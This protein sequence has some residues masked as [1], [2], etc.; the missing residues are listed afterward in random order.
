MKAYEMGPAWRQWWMNVNACRALVPNG[1][2]CQMLGWQHHEHI[3]AGWR[4]AR[5]M[6]S[7][8]REGQEGKEPES[9]SLGSAHGGRE[10]KDPTTPPGSGKETR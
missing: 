4:G 1:T 8:L 10:T 2:R 3:S 7:A 5:W 9:E 6:N